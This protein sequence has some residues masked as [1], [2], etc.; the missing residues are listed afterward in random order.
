MRPPT[1]ARC[2]TILRNGERCKAMSRD[3]H[4]LCYRHRHPSSRHAP[5]L[6]WRRYGRVNA[7]RLRE[8]LDE[9][10]ADPDP[11]DLRP[12]AELV[13][14]LIIDY[15]ERYESF[16]EALLSWHESFSDEHRQ[17]VLDYWAENRSLP[18][19]ERDQAGEPTP[20]G[21]G[22]PRQILDV[23]SAGGLVVQLTRVVETISKQRQEGT[24]TLEA[25]NSI[26]E[27]LGLHVVQA[28]QEAV[29]NADNRSALIRSVERRWGQV[30]LP[31]STRPRE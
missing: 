23:S 8:L 16:T 11:M 21:A 22:K 1:S 3:G 2:E 15:I 10:A 31:G 9:M 13:R 27:Q 6:T 25:L 18:E 29:P 26:L 20:V 14:A 7:P 24:I 19:E 30:V 5:A 4:R 28:A 12:E 17:R